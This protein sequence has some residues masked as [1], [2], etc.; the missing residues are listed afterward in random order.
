MPPPQVA[1]ARGQK[2]RDENEKILSR[3]SVVGFFVL[4][5]V[6]QIPGTRRGLGIDA[7]TATAR[8]STWCRWLI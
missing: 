7:E 4:E 2:K 6:V 1:K 3:S 5:Q 8:C